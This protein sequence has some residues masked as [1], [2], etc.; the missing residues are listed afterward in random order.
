ML[1]ID[2]ILSRDGQEILA[3]SDYF[4]SNPDV[5]PAAYLRRIVPANIGYE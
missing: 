5:P 3:R 4:P 2:F 1:L